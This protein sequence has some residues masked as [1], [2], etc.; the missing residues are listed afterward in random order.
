MKYLAFDIETAKVLPEDV[1]DI[2]AHRPLGI[3]CAAAWGSDWQRPQLWYG[4]QGNITNAMAPQMDRNEIERM[5]GDLLYWCG[6][7]GDYTLVSWNGLGFDLDIMAEES[8]LQYEC[9]T[10]ARSHIDMMFHIYRLR[11]YPVSLAAVGEGMNIAQQKST[12]ISGKSAPELWRDGAHQAVLD[13]CAQDV[14][15]TLEIAET[16]ERMQEIRWWSK[17][18][19]QQ[20]INLPDGW[21]TVREAMKLPDPDQSWMETPIPITQFTGW[22]GEVK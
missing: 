6:I 2:K 15:A 22:L 1:E 17:R 10:L 13:Y 5:I 21:L 9:Q 18:G 7:G 3:T 16:C 4:I 19:N 14:R 12:E 11:G 20:W 8:G